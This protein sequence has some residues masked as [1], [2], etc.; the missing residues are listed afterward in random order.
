MLQT[1][2]FPCHR[3]NTSLLQIRQLAKESW[4]AKGSK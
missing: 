1:D 4:Q 3:G 2:F